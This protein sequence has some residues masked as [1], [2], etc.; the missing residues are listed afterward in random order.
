[1]AEKESDTAMS[2]QKCRDR[3]RELE[4]ERDKER[5]AVFDLS[6]QLTYLEAERDKTKSDFVDRCIGWQRT[7][8][9]LRAELAQDYQT[10]HCVGRNGMHRYNNQDHAMM[11]GLLTARNI[12][13]GDRRYD[14]WS[15]NEDAEYHEEVN[16]KK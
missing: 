5:N 10:F 4:A 8:D 2:W 11:T 7:I 6:E 15:V 12:M 3:V 13:A 1:M 9:E 14:V 16:E